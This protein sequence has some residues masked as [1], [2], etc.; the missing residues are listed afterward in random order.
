[1]KIAGL[2]NDDQNAKNVKSNTQTSI[3]IKNYTGKPQRVNGSSVTNTSSRVF[4]ICKRKYETR[5]ANSI[6]T[7][8][9]L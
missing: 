8:W 2:E 7:I 3:V 5:Q 4:S 9:D 6:V 1:M